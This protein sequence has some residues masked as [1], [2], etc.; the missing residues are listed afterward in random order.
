MQLVKLAYKEGI[1]RLD[2]VINK[3][4]LPEYIEKDKK[5]KISILGCEFMKEDK[6]EPNKIY[7]LT[8][9]PGAK[10]IANGNTWSESVIKGEK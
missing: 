10:C 4:K 5:G 3:N 6:P 8:G 9:G 2:I 7:A 1:R